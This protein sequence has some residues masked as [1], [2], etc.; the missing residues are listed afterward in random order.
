M[1]ASEIIE[2]LERAKGHLMWI[3]E[4]IAMRVGYQKV[5]VDPPSWLTPSG[6]RL[7]RAPYFTLSLDRAYE[8]AQ[9]VLPDSVVAVAQTDDGVIRAVVEGGPQC[10]GANK[11]IAVIIATLKASIRSA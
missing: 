9:A 7:P 6:A 1:E 3:D 11:A 10:E 5:G 4:V 2:H 8:F